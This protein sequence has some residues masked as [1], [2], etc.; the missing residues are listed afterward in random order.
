[1][2]K[3]AHDEQRLDEARYRVL[4]DESPLP[5]WVFDA[6]TLEFLAVNDA[7]I[8]LYG[9]SR[10]EFLA[11]KMPDLG[12][13]EP[14]PERPRSIANTRDVAGARVTRHHGRDGKSIELEIVFREISF[15]GRRAVFAIGHDA[16][17][18]RGLEEH[19]RQAQRTEVVGHLARGMAYDFNNR[20]ALITTCATLLV[21]RC[22]EE[23]HRG[24]LE[25]ILQAAHEASAW[26]RQLLEF[27]R[28]PATQPSVLDL[29]DVV[30]KFGK[31]LHRLIG[32]HIDF[33]ITLDVDLGYFRAYPG[34]VHEILLNLAF[35]ARDAMPSGGKL[36]IQ[37]AN[38]T[39]DAPVASTHA[40]VAPG[41][42]V[43]VSMSDTGIGIDAHAQTRIFEPFFTTKDMGKGVGLGLSTVLDIV[44]ENGGYV[45]VQ[46]EIGRGTTF[47]VYLPRVEVPA[48]RGVHIPTFE[49]CQPP[50]AGA[51][52]LVEDDPALRKAVA[53]ILGAAGYR[54]LEA[55]AASEARTICEQYH[56]P[57]D[58][59]MIDVLVPGTTGSALA[60]ELAKSRP[61]MKVLFMSGSSRGCVD[62]RHTSEAAFAFLENPFTPDSVIRKVK[63]VL[64][65]ADRR[66]LH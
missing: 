38:V 3:R 10:P 5:S 15:G 26:T 53:F 54:I 65:R 4:F 49:R 62:R 36:T 64:A 2:R 35:N 42:Y 27:C 50:G 14:L 60:N 29:N 18:A 61:D 30:R 66:V 52:V 47:K 7:A 13:P 51:I 28:Q 23:L 32:G 48:R 9:F 11:M 19:S 43:V 6:E 58:L 39:L 31:T 44:Q 17:F 63:E 12:R 40:Q 22:D 55:S 59:L 25:E 56:G 8:R 37:T 33:V 45:D 34:Q 41:R 20:L 1:M 16:T 57:I 46:S 21:E 24:A